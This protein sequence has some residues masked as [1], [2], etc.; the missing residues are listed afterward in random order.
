MYKIG[1]IGGPS[2]GKSTLAAEIFSTCK[3]NSITVDLVQE[4]AREIFNKGWEIKHPGDQFKLLLRQ[5]EREDIIPDE[6]DVMVT[7]SPTLLSYI[8]VLQLANVYDTHDKEIIAAL[9]NEFLLDLDRY[10]EL[11]LLNRVKGYVADGT[12]KQTAEESDKIY[13]QLK[14]ILD[15]HSIYYTSM[16]GDQEAC[17][18]IMNKIKKEI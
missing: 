5:R 3:H 17:S 12:R 14:A 8:Y 4:Y 11:I 16:D 7:D 9:Y 13:E 1:I 2:A 10:D 18:K 15:L 6:I